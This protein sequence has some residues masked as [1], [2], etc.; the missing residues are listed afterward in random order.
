MV[1]PISLHVN[2]LATLRLT[3]EVGRIMLKEIVLQ[4]LG[5]THQHFRI[6]AVFFEH[7]IKVLPAT[8]N[9]LGKPNDCL[10][11]FG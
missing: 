5:D 8:W 11:F 6:D 2:S 1:S 3:F 9:L 10:T 4:Y 7:F